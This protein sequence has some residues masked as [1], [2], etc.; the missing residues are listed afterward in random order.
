MSVYNSMSH[1]WCNMDEDGAWWWDNGELC[2]MHEHP[3]HDS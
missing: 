1:H 3:D 2:A